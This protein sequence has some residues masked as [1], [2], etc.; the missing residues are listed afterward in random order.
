[1]DAMELYVTPFGAPA[2]ERR[3][4]IL[5]D[6]IAKKPGPPHDF[7]DVLYLVA[8]ERTTYTLRALM[9][10]ALEEVT[11]RKGCIPP[12]FDTL[13]RFMD[14]RASSASGRPVVDTVTRGLVVEELSK[15][16]AADAKGLDV[17]PDTLAPSIAPL[18]L[19]ALDKSYIYNVPDGALEKLTGGS[20]TATLLREVKRRYETWLTRNGLADPAAAKAAYSPAPANFSHYNTVVLDGF[21]DA[22]PAE[23]RLMKALAT[24]PDFRS[25]LEAPGLT[26][27]AMTGA[28]MPYHG[29]DALL[30]ALGFPVEGRR[31]G[32]DKRDK[33]AALVSGALFGG[34]PLRRAE[35]EARA[36]IPFSPDIEIV[37]AANPAEEVWYIAGS[38]KES[39]LDGGQTALDRVVVYFPELDAYLPELVRAF[40][41]TGI[42]FH[43]SSGIPLSE[44]PVVGAIKDLLAT[45]LDG[46]R[47][48]SM[49][50]LFSSPLVMLSDG[51]NHPDA[52]GRFARAERITGGRGRWMERARKPSYAPED[53]ADVRGPLAGLMKLMDSLP[54]GRARLSEWTR[55]LTEIVG[56]SG[57]PESVGRLSGSM[58]ELAA[59]LAEIE[60][61]IKSLEDAGSMLHSKMELAEF[62]YILTKTISGR[63][64]RTG[65]MRFAGVRVLG[66]LELGSEPCDVIYAGGLTE[67]SLP[68]SFRPDIFFPRS[69]TD[70]LGMP[71]REAARSREARRFLGIISSSQ[72]AFLCHPVA[73][74]RGP[75]PP[76]PYIRAFEPLV[77]AGAV[78]RRDNVTTRPLEPSR[79]LSPAGLIRAAALSASVHG[80]WTSGDIRRSLGC[81][82]EGTPGLG[83]ALALLGPVATPKIPSA[84]D[85][86]EFTV[87]EL[88]EYILCGFRYYHSRLMKSAPEEDPDDDIAPHM[89]GS[90]VHKI[91]GEFYANAKVP[92]TKENRAESLARLLD[93]ADRRFRDMPDTLENSEF[94]RKFTEFLAPRFIDA[95]AELAGTGYMVC[96]PEKDIRLECADDMAGRF[97]LKGKID[98]MELSGNGEFII[99]DYKTGAYPGSGKPLKELF[100][101][102]LYAYMIKNGA[103]GDD[104]ETKPVRPSRFVYYNLKSGAMRDVVLYDAELADEAVSKLHYTRKA[105]PEQM[106]GRMEEAYEKAVEAV[107]GITAGRFE[108]TCKKKTVC[109]RC[110]YIAICD[111]GARATQ[112]DDTDGEEAE[113]EG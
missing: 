41:A 24:V 58:P 81:I 14:S 42:P 25:V 9:L 94:A 43:V 66:G 22:D 50:R 88:E 102:P 21:Y 93:I 90:I 18:M 92:V 46:Y 27:G 28:G 87:T 95:E 105:T 89:A 96:W 29:T 55:A 86:R 73:G 84:P 91:L 103:G 8:N 47:F 11:G 112:D 16:A 71:S 62:L 68:A 15:A 59:A 111:V 52:F 39:Y 51:G 32:D 56:S 6:I 109:E 74:K 37:P 97:V 82:P 3:R 49:R 2:W 98:R 30:D 101:L 12:A 36:L 60:K 83:R 79:A 4:E 63:R 61:I 106:E 7:R 48:S 78:N 100:Q 72:K 35:A 45:P 70:G 17:G 23:L 53:A 38:I 1:M 77:H 67:D 34:L 110:V 99:S 64:Y 40:T 85:K 108:P 76:S 113:G 69:A 80:G 19:D 31:S 65:A 57:I 20:I 75:V 54:G 107:R 104:L 33:E 5:K 10:D 26:S 13:N 44:S